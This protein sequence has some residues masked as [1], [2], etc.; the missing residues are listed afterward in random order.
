MSYSFSFTADTKNEAKQ[1]AV[2]EMNTVVAQ[3]PA[4]AKDK[5]AAIAAAHAFI[6]ML[7][8][9]EGSAIQVSMNG[10]VGWEHAEKNYSG[11]ALDTQFCSAGVGVM[12]WVVPKPA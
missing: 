8:E 12:A 1:R 10:S 3:Q 6:D 2:D 7:T 11:T 4:H 5:H 9:K